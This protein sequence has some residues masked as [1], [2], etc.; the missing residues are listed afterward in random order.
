[1]KHDFSTVDALGRFGDTMGAD[2][3][4]HHH[5]FSDDTRTTAEIL[6]AFYDAIREAAGDMAV[7]GC[8]V[9]GHLAVGAI[10][11]QRIGDDTSGRTWERTR[12]MGINTLAHRL[13]QHDAFFTLD[14]DCVPA[15]PATPWEV[16][17][18]WLDLVA[19][20]GTALFV[21]VDPAVR[22]DAID[23]DLSRAIRTALDQPEATRTR[24]MDL[25]DTSTPVRWEFEDGSAEY[26]W[27]APTGAW[28][29]SI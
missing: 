2:I 22:S 29:F 20:S 10:D 14:A 27:D 19:R 18:Q 1:M 3:T 17:R 21:S 16:N 12:R 7:L 26:N 4:D 24:A 23:A 6:I 28:P 15:T 9:M 11:A 25:V 5:R 8:N 13:P